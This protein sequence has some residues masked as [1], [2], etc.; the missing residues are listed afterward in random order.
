MKKCLFGLALVMLAIVTP[1]RAQQADH[2]VIS[3]LRYYET[4]QVNEEFVELYN[5][6]NFT[7]DVSGWHIQYK[8]RT[9][10][11]WSDKTIFPANTLIPAHGFLL[12]GGN[13]VTPEPDFVSN[14]TLGLGNSGGHVRI[15]DSSLTDIDRVGWSDEADSPEGT[16]LGATERGGSFERKAFESSTEASMNSGGADELEGN[17]WDSDNN[18]SDFVTHDSISN[19]NP[20]TLNSGSEPDEPLT[21]GSGT[22]VCSL[23]QIQAPGPVS[24]TVTVTAGEHTLPTVYLEM[25]EDWTWTS[26]S[27]DGQGFTDATLTEDG[28]QLQVTGAGVEGTGTGIFQLEGVTTTTATGSYMLTVYTAVEDGT[29]SPIQSSPEIMVLGD[30]IE[31]SDLHQNDSSGLPLL[32]G[33]TVVVEGIVTV[34]DQFGITT[35]LQD[36]TGGIVCYSSEVAN[37]CVIGDR[38][39]V[40]GTVAPYSGLCELQPATIVTN[41]GQA[42]EL[43]PAVLTCAD[44]AN[45]GASGEP[46]EGTLVRINNVTVNGTGNWAGNTNYDITDGSGSTQIRVDS[47]I[48]LVGAPIPAGAFDVVAVVSQYDFSVPHHSGYQL[49]PRF[50]TDVVESAGPGII[51]GPSECMQAE[52]SVSLCWTTRET[53]SSFCTWGGVDGVIDDSVYVDEAVTEHS[54]TVPGLTAGEPYWARVGSTNETGTSMSREYWFSTVSS[55]ASPQT[56]ESFFTKSVESDLAMDG[57]EANGNHDMVSELVDLIDS[58]QASLDLCIY[59]LNIFEI[60]E[61]VIDAHDRGVAVRFIY[62]DDHSQGEVSQIENAGV[63]VIDDSYGSNDGDG[64]QHNKFIVVDGAADAPVATSAVWT[65][66]LNLIDEPASYGINAKQNVV[67]IRDRALARAYRQEFNEMWGSDELA[68][69]SVNSRFG[70]NKTNNTPHYFVVG[71]VPVEAW[72]SPGDHVAQQIINEIEDCDDAVYFSILTFTSNDIGYAMRD[73]IQAGGVVRG[74]FDDEGDAYSEWQPLIN[75][76]ADVLLDVG[77]GILHHKYMLIDAEGW[78]NDPTVITGSYNWSSSAENRNNENLVVIHSPYI[79]NQFLQEFAYQY[80]AAGGEADFVDLA[81]NEP[82]PTSPSLSAVY[83]NPFNP[84]THIAFEL[85]SQQEVN[86]AVFNLTGQRVAVLQN[87]EL[88]AGHHEVWFD[89]SAL[90]SGVYMVRLETAQNVQTAKMVLLK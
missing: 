77:S 52:T 47:D 56:I 61:A 28:Q 39:T 3:E 62:D 78:D 12:Y 32:I 87:G 83:P 41:H 48:D 5:P 65:G 49:L 66:S 7:V 76:G 25:P 73:V 88:A 6:T 63:T 45:Q 75:Y 44:I 72:F 11:D 50:A 51:S 22:A 68:P 29:P 71:G 33:Q 14:V 79:A 16:A 24:L 70:A 17:G 84:G 42:P 57:N 90:A 31:M 55:S 20:Q 86:V 64:L 21:D 74:L 80:H 81:T 26:A 89:G 1:L 58:A 23:D 82:L 9:G 30:P 19:V 36:A 10:V 60:S 40:M 27:I 35:Y 13:A 59:S 4:S 54:F 8:S 43:A 34:A 37:N 85:P 38:I 18:V 46:Y 53:G 67:L 69:N 2:I 15:T